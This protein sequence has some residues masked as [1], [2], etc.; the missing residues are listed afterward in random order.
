MDD[1]NHHWAAISTQV[2][3]VQLG[4]DHD[5]QAHAP[6]LLLSGKFSGHSERLS[7]VE[8]EAFAVVEAMMKAEHISA[9]RDVHSFT[10][11]SNLVYI[12]NPFGS[13][14]GI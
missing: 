6:L 11:H 7:T 5:Q 1:S 8:K 9:V 14:P 12:F 10:D 2:P 3:Y 13:N 4:L